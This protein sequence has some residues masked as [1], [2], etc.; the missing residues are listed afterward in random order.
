[1]I[2]SEMRSVADEV[3]R[4]LEDQGVSAR[5]IGSV[6]SGKIHEES[7]IDIEVY[8]A[9]DM[10]F[11]KFLTPI[12]KKS[13]KLIDI[14]LTRR[15]DTI[16]N[17]F[18]ILLWQNE[19]NNWGIQEPYYGLKAYA[20]AMHYALTGKEPEDEQFTIA[21]QKCCIYENGEPLF[22]LDDLQTS[23]IFVMLLDLVAQ[24][25]IARVKR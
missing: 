3:L 16:Q 17:R 22:S 25:K 9:K 4:T 23:S 7:D 15:L 2:A 18:S 12:A 8:R 21:A 1:M 20:F 13:K 5:L 11:L 10:A 24:G 6:K 19:V 14:Q